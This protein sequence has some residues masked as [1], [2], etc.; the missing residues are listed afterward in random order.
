MFKSSKLVVFGEGSA[1]VVKAF[2]VDRKFRQ[3]VSKVQKKVIA[4]QSMREGAAPR[5]AW[6]AV[7]AMQVERECAAEEAAAAGASFMGKIW[8]RMRVSR[9]RARRIVGTKTI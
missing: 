2:L 6:E 4:L 7:R 3:A 9:F 8:Y 5:M 1:A